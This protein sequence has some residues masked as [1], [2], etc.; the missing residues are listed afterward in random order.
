MC[1]RFELLIY[2]LG[3]WFQACIA[4]RLP[5]SIPLKSQGVVLG[6]T[7]HFRDLHVT[8][9]ARVSAPIHSLTITGITPQKG[10]GK[11]RGPTRR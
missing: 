1:I 8:M 11:K 5:R 10:H 3:L 4:P 6:P 2:L 9:N 7:G